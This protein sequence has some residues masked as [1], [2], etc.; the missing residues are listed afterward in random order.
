METAV[1]KK[2][3]SILLQVYEKYRKLL[4]SIIAVSITNKN[5]YESLS[6]TRSDH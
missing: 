1:I 5:T 3:F 2:L 4:V 6:I